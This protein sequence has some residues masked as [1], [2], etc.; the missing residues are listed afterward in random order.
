MNYLEQHTAK[1]TLVGKMLQCRSP[2]HMDW[3]AG[4]HWQRQEAEGLPL[5]TTGIR[6]LVSWCAAGLQP[7]LGHLLVAGASCLLSLHCRPATHCCTT[8]VG[9]TVHAQT[10]NA[11]AAVQNKQPLKMQYSKKAVVSP[12]DAAAGT[13]GGPLNCQCWRLAAPP[14][15][16]PKRLVHCQLI[17]CQALHNQHF[18]RPAHLQQRWPQP[19]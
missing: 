2:I 4:V 19:C 10:S 9:R 13:V 18:F 16:H 11:S 1:S 14:C 6:L 17:G 15:G 3:Q 8:R 12:A 7:C 5:D